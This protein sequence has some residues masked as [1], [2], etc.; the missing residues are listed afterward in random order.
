[1][2]IIT[3]TAAAATVVSAAAAA[4]ASSASGLLS[5]TART[6]ACA[7]FADI[8]FISTTHWP[9]PQ[10]RITLACAT[11]TTRTPTMDP[12]TVSTRAVPIVNTHWPT[13]VACTLLC[14]PKRDTYSTRPHTQCLCCSPRGLVPLAPPPSLPAPVR[15]TAVAATAITSTFYIPPS[16]TTATSTAATVVTL[17]MCNSSSIYSISQ[18][19]QYVHLLVA[20]IDSRRTCVFLPCCPL[21]IRYTAHKHCS[22]SSPDRLCWRIPPIPEQRMRHKRPD[23]LRLS[24]APSRK[25]VF[26]DAA[27]L[28]T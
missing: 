23:A 28:I 4:V 9:L 11:S 16:V 21:S 2:A 13:I 17:L 14:T 12:T 24:A 15:V 6:T 3:A 25:S 5:S 26:K 1:M 22:C 10:L 7:A 19:I 8:G 18:I 27:S 20:S